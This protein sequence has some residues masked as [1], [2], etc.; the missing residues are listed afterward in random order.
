MI[1][2]LRISLLLTVLAWL[3]FAQAS[4]QDWDYEI[5]TQVVGDRLEVT[6]LV[7]DP[8]F[9]TTPF[10]IGPSNFVFNFTAGVVDAT[11]S[12]TISGGKW[13]PTNPDYN[14]T[15]SNVLNAPGGNP[16]FI[17][18]RIT[19]D[20]TTTSPSG[21]DPNLAA[22]NSAVETDDTL[23]SFFV[24]LI[25]CDAT[26]DVAMDFSG[27]GPATGASYTSWTED[28]A[29][30]NFVFN[31]I[32]GSVN[33]AVIPPTLSTD[34]LDGTALTLLGGPTYCSEDFVRIE[35]T[36]NNFFEVDDPNYTAETFDDDDE[37]GTFNGT[38][39]SLRT[40]TGD[41]VDT[42]R[43]LP[44]D[45]NDPN[46]PRSL[47]VV[48]R[49][50]NGAG[51]NPPDRDL[52]V[53]IAIEESPVSPFDSTFICLDEELDVDVAA[54]QPPAVTIANWGFVLQAGPPL[55]DRELDPTSNDVDTIITVSA[56]DAPNGASVTTVEVTLEAAVSGCITV[57]TF[58]IRT[59]PNV[60]V[61]NNAPFTDTY[62]FCFEEGVTLDVEDATN[63]SVDFDI[64]VPDAGGT[65]GSD[66]RLFY[67]I[68]DFDAFTPIPGTYSFTSN[69]GNLASG[70]SLTGGAFP[71]GPNDISFDDTYTF[72]GQAWP[73]GDSVYVVLTVQDTGFDADPVLL[74]E[75]GVDPLKVC[76]YSD[77]VLLAA[78]R[79]IGW[80]VGDSSTSLFN[81]LDT[82]SSCGLG[83][84]QLTSVADGGFE[85]ITGDWYARGQDY[86]DIYADV[87][88]VQWAS[89]DG[90]PS[91]EFNDLAGNPANFDTNVEAI[92]PSNII[93]R[94]PNVNITAL[95]PPG[96]VRRF[97]I[98]VTD[99]G[100]CTYTEQVHVDPNGDVAY[101]QAGIFLEGAIDPGAVAVPDILLGAV[102]GSPG[103]LD[104]LTPFE[105]IISGVPDPDETQSEYNLVVGVGTFDHF[106]GANLKMDPGV[107]N[108][109]PTGAVDL[110]R[111][112]AYPE[113]GVTPG[114]PD[115]ASLESTGYGWLMENGTIMDFETGQFNH[116]ELCGLTVGDPY[117]IAIRHRNHL[118]LIADL[119]VNHLVG[120][121]GLP[122][123]A[124]PFPSTSPTDLRDS[125][126]LYEDPANP[127]TGTIRINVGGTDVRIAAAG[128]TYNAPWETVEVI[129]A[130]DYFYASSGP[131]VPGRENFFSQFDTDLN[132]NVNANDATFIEPNV[133][134][135]L[136]GP[137]QPN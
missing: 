37:S 81:A 106:Y 40:F 120:P 86:P 43:V 25:D 64:N 66:T 55:T 136:Y 84:E 7:S 48:F 14:S 126:N 12:D 93:A 70:F 71:T 80:A 112:E 127:S 75:Y 18:Y 60:E 123:A 107:G 29:N 27:T 21:A 61:T 135:L 38:E 32:S 9:P 31:D 98:T 63:A 13:R 122:L 83:V 113:S 111:I 69:G 73:L 134:N 23:V 137:Y 131:A 62:M 19:P 36:G 30:P 8:D 118:S 105:D 132:G 11:D 119:D 108:V 15:V 20:N 53:D 46:D 90:P 1:K 41:D 16:D 3:P 94:Q 76:N 89:L 10:A 50:D 85:N 77:S 44:S 78:S 34:P 28:G 33:S 35:V 103:L 109:V 59:A 2:A 110:V 45:L 17:S 49:Y 67:T 79:T 68:Q 128:N 92:D 96:G 121:A 57:D 42:L 4:A 52:A 133:N 129:N 99:T 24:R 54:A 82:L 102:A 116:V 117:F 130:L 56:A 6:V 124:L 88:R 26:V 72:T 97:E 5:Q 87:T 47:V 100:G 115:F 65:D 58:A 39:A 22:G 114:T 125:L 51:C 91:D 101:T 74:N 104:Q 95:P